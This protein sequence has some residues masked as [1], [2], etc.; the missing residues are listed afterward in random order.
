MS[1]YLVMLQVILLGIQIGLLLI[2][3]KKKVDFFEFAYGYV[4][5]GCIPVVAVG[6][7]SKLV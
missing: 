2:G 7:L 1:N 5:W 4:I 6:M 3:I